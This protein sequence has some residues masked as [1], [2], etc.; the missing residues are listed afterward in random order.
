M[1]S[2]T[3]EHNINNMVFE[4]TDHFKYLGSTI[5]NNLDM[6]IDRHITIVVTVVAKLNKRVRGNS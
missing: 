2:I 6:D 4:V 1:F 3:I 5:T